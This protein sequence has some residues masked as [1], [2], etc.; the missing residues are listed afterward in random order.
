MHTTFFE[1]FLCKDPIYNLLQIISGINIRQVH[2][3]VI[4]YVSFKNTKYKEI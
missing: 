3:L 2:F 4:Y 1:Y